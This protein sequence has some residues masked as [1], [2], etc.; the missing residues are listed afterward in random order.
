M[1]KAALVLIDGF[2]EIEAI[3]IMDV[4]RRGGVDVTSISLRVG[5]ESRI[6][7]GKHGMDILADRMFAEV[8]E[9]AFDVLAIPGGT[10]AYLDHEGLLAWVKR[11][12]REEKIL[13]AICAAPSVLGKAGVLRGK[14][15]TIY[16]G[17]EEYA[18]GADIQPDMVIKDGR[19]ITGKGPAA[20]IAFS[21]ALLEDIQGAKAAEKVAEAMLASK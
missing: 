5:S 20:S 12:D 9:E 13:A 6:V 2:E 7:H 19:L 8:S 4:L 1:A 14:R 16:P 3:T 10:T 17:M 18:D 21:L 11:F 15:A